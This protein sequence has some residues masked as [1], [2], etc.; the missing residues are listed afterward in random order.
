MIVSSYLA[1]QVFERNLN[2]VNNDVAFTLQNIE[3]FDFYGIQI[4]TNQSFIYNFDELL[5]ELD[6]ESFWDNSK[7]SE[8]LFVSFTAITS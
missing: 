5:L 6:L 3:L 8:E 1:Y 4:T 2:G 7:S